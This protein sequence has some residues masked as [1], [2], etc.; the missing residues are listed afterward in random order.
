MLANGRCCLAPV[1]LNSGL[2]VCDFPGL[3]PERPSIDGVRAQISA[4]LD[5]AERSQITWQDLRSQID[6]LLNSL[7]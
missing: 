5:Q 1:K 7:Q 6:K 3:V 4:L 2:R